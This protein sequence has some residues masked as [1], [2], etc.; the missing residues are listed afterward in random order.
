[1]INFENIAYLGAW[2]VFKKDLC[3]LK[4]CQLA[5]FVPLISFMLLITPYYICAQD[6]LVGGTLEQDEIWTKDYT[7]IIYK[8]LR[9]PEGITLTVMPGVTVKINQGRGI[10]ILGGNMI[11]DGNH[12]GEVDSVFLIA[13][14]TER[15]QSWK[16]KGI[17]FTGNGNELQNYFSYVNIF[18]AEIA[19]DI[20]G[21][22]QVIIENCSLKDNQNI[23]VRIFS[24]KNCKIINCLF[25]NN[26]DGIEMVASDG[27][28]TSNNIIQHCIL[29]NFNHNIY[30]LNAFG[31]IFLNNTIENNLIEGGNNGIW[32]DNG[33]GYTFGN[34]SILKNIFINIGFND[35]YA[36]LIAEDSI[37][38]KNNI[39]W[40][41]RIAIYYDPF[42]IGSTV[43]NNSFYQNEESII[44]A[45]K[46][47]THKFEGN[48]FAVN[49]I[50]VFK[51]H[52]AENVS[53]IKSNIFDYPGKK[54]IVINETRD[55]IDFT[56]N[57]WNTT[58]ESEI[59][60]LIWD[61]ED[62]PELGIIKTIPFLPEADTV[63]PISPPAN[64][65]KQLV[66]GEVK[67]SW[68]KNPEKDL[69]GYNI[70]Y[71]VF[72]NY[73]F[74]NS[75]GEITDSVY[76]L[77]NVTIS[78]SIAI[79][80]FDDTSDTIESQVLGHESPF[81]FAINYPYAGSDDI[82]CKTQVGFQ[83]FG[84]TVPYEYQSLLWSTSGDGVF[85]NPQS[86]KPFYYPGDT[87][88]LNG[89][90][91]LTLGVLSNNNVLYDSMS[92]FIFD[93]PEAYAGSDTVIF[94]GSQ[95]EISDA[96]A[97]NQQTIQWISTG[98]GSFDNDTIIHPTY[99]P[100]E[101][102][103]ENGEVSLVLVTQSECGIATDTVNLFIE[104]YFSIEGNLW[105]KNQK[106]QDGVIL[107][108]RNTGLEAR[109]AD[110]AL[111]GSDG[112]F[113]FD[114]LMAGN[115]YIYAVPDTS[116]DNGAVPGY[117][118]NNL[119]WQD[120]YYFSIGA[121][122]FDVDIYL[123][124]VDYTLPEGEGSISG[125][126]EMPSNANFNKDIY[127]NSWFAPGSRVDYCA[128]G[129]SNITVFLYNSDGE[130]LLDYTLT[131]ENGD[132]F[133][134]KLPFG[135]YIVDAEKA[136]YQTVVSSVI[137]ISPDQMSET[138]VVLQLTAD[139]I[140]IYRT[141]AFH[142]TT[143]VDV[144]PNPA[145]NSI[146]IPIGENVLLATVSIYNTM[147]Q[148][149]LK[150]EFAAESKIIQSTANLDVSGLPNGAYFGKLSS[151]TGNF[152]FVFI[153]K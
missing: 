102:D 122:T 127:C 82:M 64:V 134:N 79:T 1:M 5:L 99:T 124:S 49:N 60:N 97:E 78:D 68:D 153:K 92:L 19:I 83:I 139:K 148:L 11:V 50:S 98:D 72:S 123:P 54:N 73:S 116:L 10:Y 94:S 33:G 39:F 45:T 112:F 84:S 38:V 22:D 30:M 96:I 17:S 41:N 70:Y 8:D 28:E 88:L 135:S 130:M 115:Y 61:N 18:D 143:F 85:S 15:S 7:Y 113:K 67:L 71:G 43:Q 119:N 106:I 13:N 103:I 44:L 138:G 47:I 16:W 26:Y 108:V 14:H 131:N 147:G 52:E 111:A 2:K 110:I 149:A 100:G 4:H 46:S 53:F 76:F 132:F 6:S 40:D 126:F 36:L 125:Y 136:G 56:L 20:F 101:S 93:G 146:H 65:I 152:K 117:Y 29:K 42:T 105:Y 57:F 75:I 24:S 151:N 129:L 31:G 3:V 80:A 62:D 27:N 81:S 69:Q 66:D 109:A 48:T 114:R 137:T 121:N 51:A 21:S 91:F 133:F 118:A 107:A 58:N 90:V 23:G 37:V 34:N 35:G 120:A 145:N 77:A 63:C 55:D 74:S 140:G 9:I 141:Q 95:F 150:Q 59:Q 32:A 144:Y 12:G 87:D 128:G 104:P 142:S 25:Q 89:E 86:L